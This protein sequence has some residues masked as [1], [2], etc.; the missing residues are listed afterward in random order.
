M[1]SVFTASLGWFFS[2]CSD[3]VQD[4]LSAPDTGPAQHTKHIDTRVIFHS[5]CLSL[6]LSLSCLLFQFFSP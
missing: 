1:A 2:F 4:L 5:H 3:S 6:T